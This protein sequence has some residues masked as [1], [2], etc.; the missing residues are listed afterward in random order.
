VALVEDEAT[1]KRFFKRDASFLLKAENPL[2]EPIIVSDL[3]ILGKVVGLMR[4]L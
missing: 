3:T 1:V 2:M 4:K